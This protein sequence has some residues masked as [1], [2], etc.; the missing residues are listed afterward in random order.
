MSFLIVFLCVAYPVYGNSIKYSEVNC[1]GNILYEI[2]VLV[3]NSRCSSN[4]PP[5]TFSVNEIP[6]IQPFSNFWDGKRHFTH[7]FYTDSSCQEYNFSMKYV[8]ENNITFEDGKT[9]VT[10]EGEVKCS[11]VDYDT[12][13][14]DSENNGRINST[15]V[16]CVNCFNDESKGNINSIVIGLI[17]LPILG[18]LHGQSIN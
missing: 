4:G 15:I 8:I 12:C 17:I 1:T 5:D 13:I 3:N 6:G 7:T 18:I 9:C 16:A 2:K 10:S 11:A 14:T